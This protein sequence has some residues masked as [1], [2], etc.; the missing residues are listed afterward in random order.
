MLTETL[1]GLMPL[2]FMVVAGGVMWWARGEM[3]R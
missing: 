1:A 2:L 3:E